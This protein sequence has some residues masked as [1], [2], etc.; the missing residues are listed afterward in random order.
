MKNIF[1]V[2][3]APT[4]WVVISVMS[5]LISIVYCGCQRVKGRGISFKAALISMWTDLITAESSEDYSHTARSLLTAALLVIWSWVKRI[6][7]ALWEY[8]KPTPGKHSFTPD[9]YDAL[10]SAVKDY[11]YAPFQ[12]VIEVRYAPYPS[13]VYVS[14][15]TKNAITAEVAAEVVWHIQAAFQSYLTAY[16]L[17]VDYTAVPYV[18]DN[19]IEVVLYYA[20]TPA[21]YPAY[22]TACRQSMLMKADPA[23]RPL[24]ESDVPPSAKLVLGYR[25]EPWRDSGQIVP[26]V[27]DMATSPSILVAGPSGSGKTLFV[28]MLLER[29][30]SAGAEVTICDFKGF[31]DFRGFVKDYAIG[32]ECDAMLAKYCADFE[33]VRLHGVPDGKHHVLIFDELGSFVASKSKKEADEF[34]RMLS[35][36][37][38]MGRIFS[39][40]VI[41]LSQRFDHQTLPVSLRE[42]AT[43]KVHLGTSISPQSAGMLFPHAEI[44]SGRLDPYC[45]FYST[46]Q[47]DCDVI[48]TPKI[49]VA[50]L[51][52]RLKVLGKIN[53]G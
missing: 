7:L 5:V 14:F 29:L 36:V 22:R 24:L 1:L 52:R 34:M 46:P 2:T 41:W 35:N 28:K 21:E 12:P 30:L 9:L 16:G 11:L 51:D 32:S 8:L 4:F 50:A 27:W 53:G 39:W 20:E 40:S 3:D 19:G 45:G 18:Q 13:A 31:G 38:F 49:D 23:F 15:Y 43:I 10:Y 37:I 47:T 17:T 44:T 26:V 33:R 25:Y 42:Q 48:I 6:A